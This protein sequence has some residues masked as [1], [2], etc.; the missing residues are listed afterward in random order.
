[1]KVKD[2][3]SLCGGYD[4]SYV[5]TPRDKAISYFYPTIELRYPGAKRYFE[6]NKDILEHDVS[7]VK[8]IAKNVIGITFYVN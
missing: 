7:H 3:I 1:M 2:V 8:A 6:S 4:Y 5:L